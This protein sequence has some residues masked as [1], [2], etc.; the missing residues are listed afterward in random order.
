MTNVY[1]D[2]QKFMKACEQTT[3]KYNSEQ[4]ELYCKL[5]DEEYT[6]FKTALADADRVEQ[7]D[8]LIDMIVV[9]VGA[10][11]SGGFDGEAAWKEVMGSNFSKIDNLTGKVRKREDGKILKPT[12]WSPPNLKPFVGE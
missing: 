6:E 4:Y 12:G 7:L 10:L 2:Q 5:I 1:R 8:A 11:H 9:I 3:G